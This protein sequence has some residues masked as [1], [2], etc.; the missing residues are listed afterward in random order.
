MPE[1]DDLQS[2]RTFLEP[3]VA[4][5]EMLASAVEEQAE[6][7]AS[8]EKIVM[9]DLIGGIKSV[10]DGNLRESGIGEL[11]SK[12]ADLF[13]PLQDDWRTM[14]EST[15]DIYSKLY[16]VVADL[17]KGE[18]YNDEMGDAE[19]RA[20][21]SKLAGKISGLKGK[22][23]EAQE[24]PKEE[25]IVEIEAKGEPSKIEALLDRVK[26]QKA[27]SKGATLF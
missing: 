6:K 19:I 27:Q 16:D 17:K 15:D 5:L 23:A 12:Y 8:L 7:L 20:I 24:A 3:I 9:D 10:Y 13:D 4:A 14:T 26:R 21:H 22:P 11:K 25:P 18:G 2:D 1:H